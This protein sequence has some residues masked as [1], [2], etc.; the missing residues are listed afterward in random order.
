MSCCF[1]L[2]QLFDKLDYL[3]PDLTAPGVDIIAAWSLAASP[4]FNPEDQ[5]ITKFNIISGIRKSKAS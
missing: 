4:T 1:E 3:Q 5:R 2:N